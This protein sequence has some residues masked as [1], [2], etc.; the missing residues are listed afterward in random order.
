[1][2]S[3]CSR[4]HR[5]AQWDAWR[6]RDLTGT[7]KQLQDLLLGI[8]TGL[9]PLHVSPHARLEARTRCATT[10]R[11]HP[12]RDLT[13]RG[14][15]LVRHEISQGGGWRPDPTQHHTLRGAT[16]KFDTRPSLSWDESRGVV[17]ANG[18]GSVRERPRE[19][20]IKVLAVC[21][22]EVCGGIFG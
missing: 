13:G 17:R 22:L 3:W 5:W 10:R 11:S 16:T 9:H 6:Q 19:K 14:R 18:R 20:W 4:L 15:W 2:I 7:H 21:E 12:T 1:M 8:Q